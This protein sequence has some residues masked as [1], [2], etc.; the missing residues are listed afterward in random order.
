MRAPLQKCQQPA[1]PPLEQVPSQQTSGKQD[2]RWWRGVPD[3]AQW[4]LPQTHPPRSLQGVTRREKLVVLSA[5][6]HHPLD[7][8]L[9][10]KPLA[11]PDTPSPAGLTG[12]ETHARAIS[13][14]TM[15]TLGLG[16]KGA[17]VSFPHSRDTIT[18][19]LCRQKYI[20]YLN[21]ILSTQCLVR[22]LLH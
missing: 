11:L 2:P 13:P 18:S 19:F 17:Q 10:R 14:R 4:A 12:Q 1:P 8:L 15:T 7:C 6:R 9:P 5:Q 21:G 22:Q 16:K 20:I 3:R